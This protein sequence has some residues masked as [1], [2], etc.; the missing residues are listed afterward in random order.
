MCHPTHLEPSQDGERNQD[1][2][3]RLVNLQSHLAAITGPTALPVAM[4]LRGNHAVSLVSGTTSA[5]S[6]KYSDFRRVLVAGGDGW[7]E[8]RRT[9]LVAVEKRCSFWK[10]RE[11]LG[12]CFFLEYHLS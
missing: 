10:K 2:E 4:P 1:P 9:L 8:A 11:F 5:R 6:R 7:M 12:R 3:P